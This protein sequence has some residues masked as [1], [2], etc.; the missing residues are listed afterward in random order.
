MRRNDPKDKPH[1]PQAYVF[2]KEVG[3]LP[4]DQNRV[5]GRL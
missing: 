5:A 1:G 4:V 2:Y 3:T